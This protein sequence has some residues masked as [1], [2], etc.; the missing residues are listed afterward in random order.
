[1][2]SIGVA[3]H[4]V[5]ALGDVL[6]DRVVASLLGD[7]KQVGTRV[8]TR[9]PYFWPSKRERLERLTRPHGVL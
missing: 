8:P 3:I 2:P 9:P 4:G 5:I 6:M 7:D 1:M